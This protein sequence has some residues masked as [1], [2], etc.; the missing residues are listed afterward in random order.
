MNQQNTRF[1]ARSFWGR[2]CIACFCFGVEVK[3]GGAHATGGVGVACSAIGGG[4]FWAR[5]AIC[6][7]GFAHNFQVGID[8]ALFAKGFS[9]A[10]LVPTGWTD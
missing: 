6:F 7:G 10:I 2:T 3:G 9:F 8:L 5:R 4:S 1:D